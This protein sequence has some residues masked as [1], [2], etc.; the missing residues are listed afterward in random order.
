MIHHIFIGHYF[1]PK[2]NHD[3]IWAI[4]R[5]EQPQHSKYTFSYDQCLVVWGRRGRKLQTQ[6]AI[7]NHDLYLRMS[8]KIKK[9]YQS[10]DSERLSEV[11]PDFE[12]DLEKTVFWARFKF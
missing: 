2:E 3:K 11:Y 4:L 10:I 5:F 1:D 6:L 8:S 9:G 7:D 12:K